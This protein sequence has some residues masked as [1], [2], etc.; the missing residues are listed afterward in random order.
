MDKHANDKHANDKHETDKH[1]TESEPSDSECNHLYTICRV[2][3]YLTCYYCGHEQRR[4][5]ENKRL[6][7]KLC[8]KLCYRCN[9]Y[10]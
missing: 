6:N 1:A 3:D 10:L 8:Y 7:Y 9:Q 5:H 4:I 2:C